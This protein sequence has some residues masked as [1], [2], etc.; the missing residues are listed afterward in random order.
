MRVAVL[1]GV[2]LLALWAYGHVRSVTAKANANLAYVGSL[3]G[4]L[5]AQLSTAKLALTI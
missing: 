1:V 4:M 3:N 2:A 5:G